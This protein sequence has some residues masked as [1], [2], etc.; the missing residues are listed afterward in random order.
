MKKYVLAALTCLAGV[1]LAGSAFAATANLDVSATVSATCAI[2]G[3]TL[4][5]GSLDPTTAPLVNAT[6]T[7]VT[8]TCTNNTAYTITD[9]LTSHAGQLSDGS[10]HNIPYS[11]SYTGSGTGDGTAH[12]VDITGTIAASTYNTMPAGSYSDTVTLTALP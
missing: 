2:Q 12:A 3:G 9:S 10:G 11:I 7:G 1:A 4:D 5:F 6:S 8:V